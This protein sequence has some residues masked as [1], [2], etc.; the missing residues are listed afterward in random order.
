[1][2]HVISD[3]R[4]GIDTCVNRYM[5]I[6]RKGA[7]AGSGIKRPNT[8]PWKCSGKLLHT[9]N[10]RP[11]TKGEDARG[12]SSIRLR[13]LLW[14]PDGHSLGP[15]FVNTDNSIM[16]NQQQIQKRMKM[17]MKG[18]VC[19][20]KSRQ[21]QYILTTVWKRPSKHIVSQVV[22]RYLQATS[23]DWSPFGYQLPIFLRVYIRLTTR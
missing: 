6:V 3:D 9:Q 8:G 22:L 4:H 2:R 10:T 21:R 16:Q 5:Y 19:K 12:R 13:G 1:M 17:K 11:N 14:G 18:A 23:Y 15:A 20:R 7:A